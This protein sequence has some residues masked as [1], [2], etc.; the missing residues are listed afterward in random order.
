MTKDRADTTGSGAKAKGAAHAAGE[1]GG[2][3]R[4]W[5]GRFGASGSGGGSGGGGSSGSGGGGSAPAYR[6]IGDSLRFDRRLVADDIEGSIA[7][8]RALAG[9]GVVSPSDAEQIASALREIAHAAGPRGEGIEWAASDAEDV[10]SW[11]EAALVARV[12]SLGKRLHTGRSRNDQVATDLRLWTRRETFARLR[13]LHAGL[14]ALLRCAEREGL[15]APF[16]GYTHVQR[17]QPV[18]FGHWCLAWFEM[19]MRDAGR[20]ESAAERAAQCPLGAGALAGTAYPI[21][22]AALARSL[23]F[24]G[25]TAN[26]LDA[27]S[28][29]DFVVETLG[30]L[31]LLAVHLSRLAEDLVLH[32]SAEFGLIELSDDVATGSSLMPQKKNPDSAELLRGKTGRVVG[33]LMALLM[34]IKGTPLSYNRDYQEDKEPLF[35]AMETTSM[36]LGV[37][38]P[39]FDGLRLRRERALAAARGGHANAT[40][41]ADYLVERGVPFRDAHEA[42]GRAVRVALDKGCAL[43]NL[44]LDDLRGAGVEAQADVFPRLAL[45]S[46]LNRR[47][48]RGGTAPERVRR[49]FRRAKRRLQAMEPPAP[50]A[51]VTLRK[52]V[53]VDAG[54]IAALVNKGSH[55]GAN[56]PRTEDDIQRHIREFTVAV[57]ES[58]AGLVGCAALAAGVGG[59]AEVR[60]LAVRATHGGRG[61]G[62]AL[63]RR[64]CADAIG[65][66]FDRVFVLTTS[67]KFFERLA[68]APAGHESLGETGV[69]AWARRN[70]AGQPW[71]AMAWDA[72]SDEDRA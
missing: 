55:R 31:A 4:L 15:D 8:A 64:L 52:A 17:A 54:A 69:A 28:D 30:A 2:A 58:G 12:G 1:Q 35:D 20:L 44:S 39:M 43:E 27:V 3:A 68:F 45:E 56:L 38:A 37:L 53:A 49:A 16:P 50:G 14:G 67:P 6:A 70:R 66:G 29:R 9:A 47:D 13:E 18:T 23:G 62:S 57:S 21:D 72:E 11:V 26:S 36:T 41:L 34:T 71:K 33:S 60:S 19:L 32:A 5:G 48:V 46:V 42:A 59:V 22:R 61:V 7:W 40:D 51:G 10:H 65:L 63:V 25:S 24:A